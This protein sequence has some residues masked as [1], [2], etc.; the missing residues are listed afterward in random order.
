MSDPVSQA[1][2][3]K[4][5]SRY[6]ALTQGGR[7]ITGLVTQR[8]PYRDGAVSYLTAKYNGGSRIDTMWD[9][10]NRE[11]SNALTDRRRP[12]S[13]VY[14]ALTFPA[15][16]G[17]FSWKYIQNA[18]EIVRTLMDGQD[19]VVYDVTAGQKTVIL[20][21]AAGAGPARML[22]VNTEL[23]IGDGVE[24]KKSI[25]TA[26]TWTANTS[27]NVGDLI[28]DPNGNIQKAYSVP[29]VCAITSVEQFLDGAIE[30]VR[31]TLDQA[32]GL[33]TQGAGLFTLNP[34]DTVVL[35][36][37]TGAT[38]L[39]G[40]AL[41]KVYPFGPYGNQLQGVSGIAH[42]DYPD[43]ADT[44]T[45]TGR[46]Q[47]G[48][49][50]SG[51]SAP[52]WQTLLRRFTT[53]GTLVWQCYTGGTLQDWG[54]NTPSQAATTAPTFTTERYWVPGQVFVGTASPIFAYSVLDP[55]NNV[56][57]L[58]I[59]TPFNYQNGAS[60]PNWNPNVGGL[61]NSNAASV[62]YIN[63]GQPTSW[64]AATNYGGTA[65]TGAANPCC[66]IDSNDNLQA[67]TNGTIVAGQ[68]PAA[69]A[70]TSGAAQPVWAT[71]T[72][73]LTVDG[74][75][76][77][78]NLGPGVSLTTGA[79]Q[80]AWSTHSIDGTVSTAS[81][82]N[83][84]IAEGILGPDSRFGVN[85]NGKLDVGGNLDQ[86]DEVWLW[87]TAQNQPT[88]IRVARIPLPPLNPA[89]PQWNFTDM[90]PDK[91]LNAFV[92]APVAK[93]G[94]P[95]PLGYLPMC[96][97]LQRVWG[98]VDNIVQ[99]SAGPDAVTGN[100]LTQFPPLNFIAFVGKPYAIFPITV[101]DGG[102][103]VFT[104]SGI[105]IILG[106][107]TSSD[108]FYARPYFQSVNVSGYNAVTLFNQSFF[109]IESNLK[110]SAVAVQFPFNPSTG[111]VE[112]GFPIGDQFR[113]VT[114]GGYNSSLFNSTTAFV[115][116]NNQSTEESALYI[117]D[118]AGRWFRMS[119]LDGPEQGLVWSP[120]A[121]IAGGASAIQSAETSPGVNQLLIAPATGTTGTIRA[122]DDSGTIYT[123]DVAG[124]PTPYSAWDAKGVTLLCGTGQW[125]ET[126]HIAAKSTNTG[127]PRPIVAVLLGEIQPST[128]RPYDELDITSTD[129]P[130]TPK[131]QSVYSDR[132]G[133]AQN[134]V[135][136]TS[137]CILVKFDYGEQ[138]FGDE[139][140][141]W[142][143]FAS[144]QDER[145][146]P[147]SK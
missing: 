32:P 105:W 12:G 120:I 125:A 144:V 136:N 60:P 36:G 118:G 82:I 147:V 25:R 131:S 109:V 35:A 91:A 53:D 77:W 66:I 37:L 21:K 112:V 1:G 107:G 132:Y 133:L 47:T 99:W 4:A 38:W 93:A 17:F 145:E 52:A 130:D 94:D 135:A 138:A 71:A 92:A 89:N 103:V 86:V 98:I 39:N 95:P 42:A 142:G 64:F 44:G 140:L 97:A 72:G 115:T 124:T 114:T 113:K 51:G 116:W 9:G 68:F 81:P 106:Q 61:T 58:L 85:L 63:F 30:Y 111:Y 100:G 22:G 40:T 87:R 70:L 119:A 69:N 67:M 33:G 46:T 31:L 2:A 56:Q 74:P 6:A 65:A 15:G 101:Q 10:A 83:A 108:P 146:E 45:A 127:G 122:R 128:S 80:W 24:Q 96:F 102:Q 16:N 110:V 55:S 84:A 121:T 28:I 143:I 62:G 43:T 29:L 41:T 14:N 76:T 88:L 137:D 141:D 19:G 11:I 90:L 139:L 49:G 48:S 104:S 8:S 59:G 78:V 5:G 134:G 18:T 123:D 34:A 75:I 20:G 3:V 117:N 79:L 7:E 27:Y 54:L 73:G 23:F 126:A 13:D 129:P 26:K 57:A 50:T